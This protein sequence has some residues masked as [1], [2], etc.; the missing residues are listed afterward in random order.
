MAFLI[1]PALEN[2]VALMAGVEVAAGRAS[3]S[4]ASRFE[5]A[6]CSAINDARRLVLVAETPAD[7][8]RN[9]GSAVVGWAKT[10]FHDH[11]AGPAPAGYYLAGITVA[12]GFRRRGVAVALTD[13]RLEWIWAR[14]DEAWYVVNASNAAS[15]KLHQRWGFREVARAYGFHE[16]TFDGG[17]GLLLKAPRPLP[18]PCGTPGD[19]N[20]RSFAMQPR[21]LSMVHR[22]TNWGSV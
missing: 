10:H 11:S 2:D 6:I 19:L 5:A 17:E 1:R 12:P 20:G 9:P 16:V 13:A 7:L 4:T 18:R 8:P 15:L 3:S 14:S 22:Y 21:R